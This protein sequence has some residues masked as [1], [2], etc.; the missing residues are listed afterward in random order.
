MTNVRNENGK[1]VC[2]VDS[3]LKTVEIVQKKFKTIICFTT[4][5]KVKITNLKQAM[6]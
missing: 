1:L 6:I 4:D 5:G 3:S 2:K